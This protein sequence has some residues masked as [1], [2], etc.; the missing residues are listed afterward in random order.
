MKGHDRV[1]LKCGLPDQGL[2]SGDVGTIVHIYKNG[3]AFEVEFVSL[4]GETTVVATVSSSQVRSVHR[5]EITHAR[6]MEANI[7]T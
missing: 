3:E 7:T 1:V 6:Q 2:E 4:D 5:R